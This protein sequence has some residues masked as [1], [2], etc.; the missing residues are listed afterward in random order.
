M[1]AIRLVAV[2]RSLRRLIRLL[3]AG[4]RALGRLYTFSRPVPWVKEE[5]AP[6]AGRK[7][8]PEAT[9]KPSVKA[10]VFDVFGTVVDWRTNVAREMRMVA[11]GKGWGAGPFPLADRWRAPDPP[12]TDPIR[13]GEQ[14]HQQDEGWGK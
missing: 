12:F 10:L 14:P 13:A 8:M 4:C 9:A 7:H 11:A 6:R 5:P 2:P 1:G 3:C